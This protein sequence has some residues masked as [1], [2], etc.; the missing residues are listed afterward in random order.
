MN[1]QDLKKEIESDASKRCQQQEITIK[2]LHA[3]YKER[4][5]LVGQLMNRCRVNSMMMGGALCLW[6]GCKDE[7]MSRQKRPD[8]AK[9]T[10][11]ENHTPN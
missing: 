11:N 2:E 1:L 3:K 10:Q 8:E 6:C 4:D 9:E 5:K 7:C